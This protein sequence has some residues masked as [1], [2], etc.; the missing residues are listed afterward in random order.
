MGGPGC[1]ASFS[2]HGAIL[3]GAGDGFWCLTDPIGGIGIGAAVTPPITAWIMVNYGWQTAFYLSSGLGIALA[4][5]WWLLARDHPADHPW[6]GER[7]LIPAEALPRMASPAIPWASLRRTPTVWWLALSYSCLGYV[8]Y[9]YMSWFYLYLVNVR[10]F[11]ILRG[12]LFASAPFLAILL[13]CPIGGWATDRLVLRYGI[14]PGRRKAGMAGMLLAAAAIGIGALVDSPYLAIASLSLGAGWLYFTVGAYWSSTSDLSK[15][16]AG[17]LSGLMNTG[18][19]IGGAIS[20]TVTPWIA[21]Q[22]GWPVSLGVAAAIALIGGILWLKVDPGKG[23]F[24]E[25]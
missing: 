13:F 25:P 11:D 2:R 20:P 9:V 17:S 8:A 19:N 23:L 4:A 12:G 3:A 15:V 14:T 18:A 6:V 24:R 22:W 1:F 5:I 7:H 10:G 16:H 21:E